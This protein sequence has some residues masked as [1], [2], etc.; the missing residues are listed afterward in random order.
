MQSK[1][2]NA[3]SKH[4]FGHW[5]CGGGTHV[6]LSTIVLLQ[7]KPHV[8]IDVHMHILKFLN[9]LKIEF[10]IYIDSWAS[11]K[12]SNLILVY[13]RTPDIKNTRNHVM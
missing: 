13:I 3:F 11:F 1:Y 12:L 9:N 7:K 10:Y 5:S 8:Y 6:M 4:I 2:K